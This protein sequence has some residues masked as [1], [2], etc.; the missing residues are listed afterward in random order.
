MHPYLIY[1]GRWVIMGLIG[2]SVLLVG[3]IAL[4]NP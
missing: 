3:F 1:F 4:T 2:W